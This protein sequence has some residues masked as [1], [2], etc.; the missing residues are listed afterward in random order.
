MAQYIPL[1]YHSYNQPTSVAAI[2]CILLFAICLS[3]SYLALKYET[4]NRQGVC[5][6]MFYYGESAN[7]IKS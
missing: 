2:L 5:N 3:M 4:L 1:Y 6:P 7:I